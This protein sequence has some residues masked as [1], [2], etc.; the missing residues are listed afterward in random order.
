MPSSRSG[1]K[2]ARD[3]VLEFVGDSFTCGY[4]TLSHRA[5]DP[6]TPE[7]EDCGKSYAGI[8]SRHFGADHWIIAHSGMGVARN[9][10]DNVPGWYMP[11]RYRQTFDEKKQPAWNGQAYGIKPALTAIYLATNDVSSRKQRFIR[12]P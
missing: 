6:F 9:Y 10:G 5:S 3:R 7:T 12:L 2:A 4:G 1:P 8:L 11:D